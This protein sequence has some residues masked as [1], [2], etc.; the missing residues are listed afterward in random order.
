MSKSSF[1][2]TILSGWWYNTVSPVS[3]TVTSIS[4][5]SKHTN[6]ITVLKVVAVQ[7]VA[8]LLRIHNIFVDNEGG[9]LGVARNALADLANGPVLAEEIEQLLRS[10]VVASPGLVGVATAIKTHSIGGRYIP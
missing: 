2:L 6:E 9:A 8:G 5:P 3:T 4:T 7:F 10:D 1:D